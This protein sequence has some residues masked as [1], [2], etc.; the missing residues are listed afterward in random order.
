MPGHSTRLSAAGI[1]VDRDV[2]LILWPSHKTMDAL[3]QCGRWATSQ[4][5]NFT[6]RDATV[7]GQRVRTAAKASE[8]FDRP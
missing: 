7:L 2:Y 5:L 8:L 1:V 4:E 3:R 6:W